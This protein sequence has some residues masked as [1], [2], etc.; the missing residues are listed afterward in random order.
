LIPAV[1]HRLLGRGENFLRGIE[2][3]ETLRQQDRSLSN[4]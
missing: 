2:V 3:R 4:A 1:S